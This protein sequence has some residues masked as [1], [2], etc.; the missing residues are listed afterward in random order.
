[1]SLYGEGP[2]YGLA[3]RQRAAAVGCC[4]ACRGELYGGERVFCMDG[5]TR[6]AAC[7]RDWLLELLERTKK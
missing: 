1:M 4:D 7:F 5:E 3:D 2:D 6:C